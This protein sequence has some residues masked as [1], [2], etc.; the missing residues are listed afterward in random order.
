M[1]PNGSK[2]LQFIMFFGMSLFREKWEEILSQNALD[3]VEIRDNRYN[4][5]CFAINF[6]VHII[7]ARNMSWKSFSI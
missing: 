5:V 6:W 3:E 2:S 7:S 4:Q 1:N